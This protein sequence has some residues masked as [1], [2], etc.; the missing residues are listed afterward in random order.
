MAKM[1]TV[2][3]ERRPGQEIGEDGWQSGSMRVIPHVPLYQFSSYGNCWTRILM[4]ED[5]NYLKVA[6][7]PS[8]PTVESEW[9]ALREERILWSGRSLFRDT[10]AK[11]KITRELPA[12]VVR[13]MHHHLGTPVAERLLT[14][15]IWA[16]VSALWPEKYE[17]PY[18][19]TDWFAR[20]GYNGGIALS[21][22]Q[23]NPP[24]WAEKHAAQERA[25]KAA[26]E[27]RIA[28]AVGSAEPLNEAERALG[29]SLVGHDWSYSYSDCGETW[30]RGN[31]HRNELHAALVAM[32]P[33]R[34]RIVWKAFVHPDNEQYWKCPV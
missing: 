31:A 3:F 33:E 11:D 13:H 7:T 5:G 32:P 10:L 30:R 18:D 26:R 2:L 22:I 15:D 23:K 20:N 19:I 25:A 12:E 27:A 14:G 1:P 9:A 8:N 6:L 29:M 28:E 17:R 21:D 24:T 16:E 4:M 34:A